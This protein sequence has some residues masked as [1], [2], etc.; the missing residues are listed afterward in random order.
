MERKDL[1]AA[2]AQIF[3]AQGRALDRPPNAASR[4]WLVGNPAR[5]CVHCDEIGAI[6]AQGKLT[7]MMRLDHNRALSTGRKDRQDRIVDRKVIVWG[8]HSPTC[9]QTCDLQR[10]MASRKPMIDD[11]WYARTIFRRSSV[12]AARPSS[13]R[14]A[15]VGQRRLRMRRSITCA[16]GPSGPPDAGSRGRGSD[17]SLCNSARRYLR[18]PVRLRGRL[19]RSRQGAET[20]T[21]RGRKMDADAERAA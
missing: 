12:S 18:R 21:F 14:A 15:I 10:S 16:I 11:G 8:N 13:R 2:N 5:Q 19:V 4:C 7:A 17:G 3:T 6:V 9:I 1:L 20:M